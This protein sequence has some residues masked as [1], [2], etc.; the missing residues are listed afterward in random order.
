MAGFLFMSTR[1]AI[2]HHQGPAGEHWDLM[3]ERGDGLLTW[4]L[5]MEPISRDVLPI[6]A[7]R[8]ADHR[9][10]YLTYEGPIS[11]DRGTV[12]RVDGGSVDFENVTASELVVRLAGSRLVGTFLLSKGQD[13]WEFRAQG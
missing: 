11:D 10:K 1:F 7:R 4:Q 6:E 13:G 5:G 9:K 8:I 2:L 12:R 3:L